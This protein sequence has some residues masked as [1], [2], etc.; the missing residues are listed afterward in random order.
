M[1]TKPEK[2]H[3][4][5][6]QFVGDWTYEADATM[7]PG[8][9]PTRMTGTERVSMIGDLWLC[10]D[11]SMECSGG[12]EGPA[13]VHLTRL[14][15]GYD[16]LKK[17]FVGSWIGSMMPNMWVYEGV[18]D[19]SGKV[20]PLMTEGPSFTDPTKLSK[21]CD[22]IAMQDADHRTLTSATVGDDGKWWEFMVARYT[23]RK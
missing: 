20:L 7:E 10:A 21:Y 18:L 11:G 9:P 5:L 17:K 15:V 8:K 16:P 3:E 23:R 6:K 12:P 13:G 14:T 1:M 19:E 22:T 4:W 2:Q